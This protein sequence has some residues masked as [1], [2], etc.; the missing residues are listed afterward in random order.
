MKRNLS[1]KG[2]YVL[3]VGQSQDWF[4][5]QVSMAP[6]LI[7]YGIIARRLHDNPK[8][9][10][11]GNIYWKWIQNYVA[12]D[13][14]EAVAIGSCE[15]HHNQLQNLLTPKVLLERHAVLQSSSRIE[16]LVQIFIHATKVM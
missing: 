11:E 3:D 7:G 1:N 14:T 8:T 2:R 4:A 6:C 16:D 13:Y 5:L 10:R 15:Y 9:K 12:D